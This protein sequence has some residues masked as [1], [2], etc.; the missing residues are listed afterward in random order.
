MVEERGGDGVSMYVSL[1][2]IEVMYLTSSR[3][4]VFSS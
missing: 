1:L 4:R 2:E 3:I